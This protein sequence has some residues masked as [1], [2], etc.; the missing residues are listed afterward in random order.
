[1]DQRKNQGR[2]KSRKSPRPIPMSSAQVLRSRNRGGGGPENAIIISS[3]PDSDQERTHP[4]SHS[5]N[6]KIGHGSGLATE[7]PRTAQVARQGLF[8]NDLPILNQ[9]SGVSIDNPFEIVDLPE[10]DGISWDEAHF[11]T[12]T[13]PQPRPNKGPQPGIFRVTE[14]PKADDAARKQ[15]YTGPNTST[16]TRQEKISGGWPLALRPSQSK[17]QTGKQVS[18]RNPSSGGCNGRYFRMN[19]N[20]NPPVGP[21]TFDLPNK[22][23]YFRANARLYDLPRSANPGSDSTGKY[24]LTGDNLDAHLRHT[25]SDT[26]PTLSDPRYKEQYFRVSNMEGA[27]IIHA[28]ATVTEPLVYQ[29]ARFDC[30]RVLDSFSNMSLSSALSK[31]F[32]SRLPFGPRPPLNSRE[33]DLCFSRLDPL[34]DSPGPEWEPQTA[35]SLPRISI[36]EPQLDIGPGN[37]I[38][39]MLARR[40]LSEEGRE[41]TRAEAEKKERGDAREKGARKEVAEEGL[42]EEGVAEEVAVQDE[43]AEEEVTEEKVAAKDVDAGIVTN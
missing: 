34:P 21:A 8:T 17:P 13:S 32:T 14:A 11:I 23:G 42:V 26:R 22:A 2:R 28:S 16:S 30:S 41:K 38:E 33:P 29:P 31:G 7:P 18:S 15:V 6:R 36:L 27:S 43:V 40:M 10:D 3:S 1:M 20:A 37:N 5:A 25:P 9:N 12:S 4:N 19:N 39:E 35:G 24:F